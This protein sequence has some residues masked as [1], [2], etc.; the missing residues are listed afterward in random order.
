MMVFAWVVLVLVLTNKRVVISLLCT[1]FAL[2]LVLTMMLGE[3]W[4]ASRAANLITM[5]TCEGIF[6]CIAFVF[7]FVFVYV[8]RLYFILAMV[9]MMI[10]GEC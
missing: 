7:V 10:P 1:G 6:I 8:F 5:I 9:T 2:T 4:L 3:C